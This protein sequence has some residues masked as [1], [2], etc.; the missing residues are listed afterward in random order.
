MPTLYIIP[1]VL[2]DIGSRPWHD[3][4]DV[5]K[6]STVAGRVKI[7]QVTSKTARAKNRAKMI[8]RNKYNYS[9]VNFKLKEITQMRKI[10]NLQKYKLHTCNC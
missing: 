6:S 8:S 4:T 10:A 7:K 1:A 2:I 5:S 3:T 9:T